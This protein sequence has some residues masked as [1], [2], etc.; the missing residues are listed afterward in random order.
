[1]RSA[2][3][4]LLIVSHVVQAAASPRRMVESPVSCGHAFGRIELI[5]HPSLIAKRLGRR[6]T[7]GSTDE[8]MQEWRIGRVQ[9]AEIREAAQLLRCQVLNKRKGGFGNLPKPPSY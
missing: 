3:G 5:A 7:T 4:A 2:N 6:L 1:V 8:D 9:P